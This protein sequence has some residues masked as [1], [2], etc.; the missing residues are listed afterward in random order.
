[1]EPPFETADPILAATLIA[2]MHATL[3]DVDK[4]EPTRPVYIFI[5]D[6]VPS[7]AKAA[8]EAGSIR[9]DPVLFCL[10]QSFL[11]QRTEENLGGSFM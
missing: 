4:S 3:L 10:A 5:G 8:F 9:V 11:R 7:G 2:S 6:T 1:M